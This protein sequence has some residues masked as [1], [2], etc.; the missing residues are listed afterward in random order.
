[1]SV[2]TIDQLVFALRGESLPQALGAI[3]QPVLA[4]LRSR[5]EQQFSRRG[6][7]L[8]GLIAGSLGL[9]TGVG[10]PATAAAEPLLA[11]PAAAPSTILAE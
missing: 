7:V 3:D 5:Q 10:N 9:V 8:A 4:G 6:L 2:S 1:M 11:T